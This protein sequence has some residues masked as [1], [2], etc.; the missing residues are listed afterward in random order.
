MSQDKTH[1]S[2][3]PSAA[4]RPM[5]RSDI[6]LYVVTVLI[7]GS[8]WIATHYQAASIAP[9]V[10]IVWRYGFATPLMFAITIYRGERLRYRLVDHGYFVALGLC[11]FSINYMLFYH[12]AQHVSSGLLSIEFT[13]AAVGNVLLGA[14][15]FGTRIE[16][17]A[18]LGGLIGIVGVAAMFYPQ[19]KGLRLDGGALLGFVLGLV[20]TSCFCIGNMVSLSAKRRNLPVFATLSWAMLYGTVIVALV[21]VAKGE[22]FVMDWSPIYLGSLVFLVLLAW[23]V[24]FGT[25]FTLLNRIGAAR[26]GYSTVLYPVVALAASTWLEDY[27]WTPVAIAGLACVLCGVILVLRPPK[28]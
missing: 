19:I 10:S 27:R 6:V 24:G 25:Y 14:L 5:T 2:A 4:L 16:G 1:S 3:A 17:R 13:L 22:A 9:E 23:V 7:W 26:A 11:I 8:S 15:V 20:A 18:V 12:A 28:P 21:G